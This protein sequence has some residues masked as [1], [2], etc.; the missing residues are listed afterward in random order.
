MTARPPRPSVSAPGLDELVAEYGLPTDARAGLATLVDALAE[1]E[2]APTTVREPR[3]IVADHI[4]DSLVALRVTELRSAARIADLGSGAGLPGIPLALA[5]PDTEVALVESNGRK[6]GF[7]ARVLERLGSPANVTV[8]ASRA[9][10][11][12]A[13]LG[14]HDA[15][16]ARALAPLAVVLEYA[17]PLLRVGGTLIVWRG[18][19]D[20]KAEAE[21][22]SAAEMLGLQGQSPARVVPYAG[23][24]HRHL[25]LFSKVSQTPSTYPRR[26]GMALKRPLG[27][28]R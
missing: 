12:P 11:W 3:R 7:I 6:A 18:R 21:A 17:A 19:R 16:T 24:E 14:A 2:H 22:E 9:E 1:D 10:E 20:L 23:A 4:A 28:R 15:I 26:S 13:G 8:V 27:A 5:L 25:H